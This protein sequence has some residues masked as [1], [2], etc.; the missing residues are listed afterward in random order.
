MILESPKHTRKAKGGILILPVQRVDHRYNTH[1]DSTDCPIGNIFNYRE[2]NKKNQT[3]VYIASVKEPKHAILQ[4]PPEC[5]RTFY[6]LAQKGLT[7]DLTE[8]SPRQSKEIKAGS[9]EY[10]L[11]VRQAPYKPSDIFSALAKK[12]TAPLSVDMNE[13]ATAQPTAE[14]APPKSA[15]YPASFWEKEKKKMRRPMR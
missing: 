12:Q 5:F 10:N 1:Y 8:Y 2:S 9:I 11:L 7:I 13:E 4:M 6:E 14:V 15:G 3:V